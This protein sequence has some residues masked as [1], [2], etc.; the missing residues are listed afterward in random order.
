[1]KRTVPHPQLP[2]STSPCFPNSPFPQFQIAV[3]NTIP[4]VPVSDLCIP[5]T[6][7]VSIISPIQSHSHPQPLSK[8]TNLIHH[9]VCFFT[10]TILPIPLLTS[11][12]Q[13][14]VYRSSITKNTS[15]SSSS[16][17]SSTS[18]TSSTPSTTSTTFLKQFLTSVVNAGGKVFQGLGL[19]TPPS[20]KSLVD[21]KTRIVFSFP[22][23]HSLSS[24]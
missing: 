10:H 21:E 2:P 24:L 19:T 18:S 8:L 14:N 22:L 9:R 15:S 23:P 5:Q 17:S 4:S 6:T 7:G 13:Y 16:S 11:P 3:R 1:M 12:F 20:T